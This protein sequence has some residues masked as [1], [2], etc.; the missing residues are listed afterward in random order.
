MDGEPQTGEII[1]GNN[2]DQHRSLTRRQFLKIAGF[3]F[4]GA[5]AAFIPPLP[6]RLADPDTL[7]E[8]PVKYI[9]RA[10]EI[11]KKEPIFQQ[12][13][14]ELARANIQFDL[15]PESIRFS[16]TLDNLVGLVLPY[17]GS[18]SRRMGASLLLSADLSKKNIT[19]VQHLTGWCLVRSLTLKS[20]IYDNRLT[21]H[22]EANAARVYSGNPL[23]MIGVRQEQLWSFPRPNSPPIS[24]E[25]LVEF[26]WPP[27]TAD[28][29][30]WHFDGCTA[31]GWAVYRQANLFR[32]VQ[33]SEHRSDDAQ[34][35]RVLPLKYTG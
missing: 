3:A 12:A 23:G 6:L 13:V 27:E 28:S 14:A 5:A 24:P 25:D 30:Y 1:P 22:A 17:R 10:L 8:T 4:A 16:S 15:L 34:R 35:A 32:C 7:R 20:V 19:F 2:L 31:P 18:P 29:R 11:A 21:P 26:G 33:V 9:Q